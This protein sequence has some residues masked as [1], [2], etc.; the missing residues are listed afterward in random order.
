MNEKQY[1]LLNHATIVSSLVLLDYEPSIV[2]WITW[3]IL[4]FSFFQTC[5]PFIYVKISIHVK[6]DSTQPLTQETNENVQ[7]KYQEFY[8]FHFS[9]PVFLH[10]CQNFHPCE[11]RQFSALDSGNKWK[12]PMKISRILL[13]SFFQSCFPSSMSKVL[14]M[15]KT[16]VLSPLTQETNENVQW[17]Y[18]DV[19]QL[20]K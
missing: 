1:T 3:R 17:K 6:D 10:L 18:Q 12:C 15:W 2:W 13:F 8:C 16:T 19:S 4:L 7:W 20:A 14:S 9:N 11:R 5:F